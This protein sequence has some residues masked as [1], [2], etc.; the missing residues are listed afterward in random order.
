FSINYTLVNV[1]WAVGSSLGVMV[2]GLNPLLPFYLSGGLALLTV[3]TLNFSLRR[4][5]VPSPPASDVIP[6][7]P[8]NF[9]QTLK[10]LRNDRR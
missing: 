7:A 1:G 9:R 5:R 8:P 4:Q 2:A 10:I 6:T 3:T